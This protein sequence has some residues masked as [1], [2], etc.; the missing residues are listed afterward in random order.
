MRSSALLPTS[1]RD[2][3]GATLIELMMALVILAIGLLAVSQLFPA[4]A[5]GQVKDRMLSTGSCY[6]Q[7]KLEELE[8]RDWSDADLSI[9]RHPP[10]TAVDSLGATRAWQR[11]YMVEALAAPLDNL[12][13][14][15]VTVTWT[16]LA[17]PRQITA[18]TYVRR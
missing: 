1:D 18:T 3:R 11:F 17:E 4:G 2:D 9:G 6:A 8:A 16:F 14:V 5:R 13:K 7:E 10:G 15:T 12:R